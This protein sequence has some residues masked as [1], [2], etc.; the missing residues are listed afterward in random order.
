MTSLAAWAI[1]DAFREAQAG[2][3]VATTTGGLLR[4]IESRARELQEQMP[5]LH[6]AQVIGSRRDM[7]V[8]IVMVQPASRLLPVQELVLRRDFELARE[9]LDPAMRL[10][11]EVRCCFTRDDDLPDDLLPRID[12]VVDAVDGG[13]TSD[14]Q[15]CPEA[16]CTQTDGAPCAYPMCPQRS[17]QG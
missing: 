12:A 4:L 14:P 11:H 15:R 17:A 1:A 6:K 10:L 2:K 8:H 13:C 5:N 16:G 3:F 7:G 9:R